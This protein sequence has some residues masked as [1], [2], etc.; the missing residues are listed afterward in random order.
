ME[1]RANISCAPT[2]CSELLQ[3]ASR[4]TAG[5]WRTICGWQSP[6]KKCVTRGQQCMPINQPPPWPF[7]PF[8]TSPSHEIKG[9]TLLLLLL[10]L[11]SSSCSS[12]F[13]IS[14][15][16]PSSSP[17]LSLSSISYPPPPPPSLLMSM[18]CCNMCP[19]SART[20]LRYFSETES[21]RAWHSAGPGGRAGGQEARCCPKAP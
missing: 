20:A 12:L 5:P 11:L 19:R 3:P 10:L 2:A 16:S 7:F 17:T 13:F 14:R 4:P 6:Q 18:S 8:R 15:S 9:E 21:L 1:W